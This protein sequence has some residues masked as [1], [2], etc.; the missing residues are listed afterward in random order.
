MPDKY[1]DAVIVGRRTLTDRIAEFQIAAADDRSLPMAE[2][3]THLELRFGGADGRFLRHYSVVGPLTLDPR[4][5]SFWRIA[6]QHEFRNRGSAFL[7]THVRRGARLLVSRPAGAFRLR[8]NAPHT[9]LVAGGI[10]ITA[11]LPMMR[12]LAVRGRSFS[13]LYA[14]TRRAAMAYADEVTAIGGERVHLHESDRNGLPDLDALL[15]GQP[16]GTIVHVCG[17]PPMIEALRSRARVRGWP[18]ERVRFEVFNAAHRPDDTGFTVRLP[19]G[20]SVEVGAGITILDALEAAGVDTL[21][22]CRRGECGLCA[23]D[24]L[25]QHEG[26]DHRDSYLTPEEK[27]AATQLTLCCSRARGRLIDLDL[28]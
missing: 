24:V 4:P 5:E 22:D 7:H 3:G 2:A 21:S 8:R 12:S 25:D 27:T 23:T 9:L 16:P 17:P 26:I 28:S 20:R 10:G 18:D 6:V 11:I 19:S 14:G 13:M 1:F 15:A